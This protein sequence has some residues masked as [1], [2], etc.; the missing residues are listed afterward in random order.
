MRKLILFLLVTV[1][2]GINGVLF[3][4]NRGGEASGQGCPLT[5][6]AKLSKAGGTFVLP[7]GLV[8]LI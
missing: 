4:K 1:L 8:V 5:C 3:W 7:G 2:L 6:S